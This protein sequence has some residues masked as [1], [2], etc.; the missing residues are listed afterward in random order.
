MGAEYINIGGTEFRPASFID[1][2]KKSFVTYYAGKLV[3]VD[4]N[5]AWDIIQ[6]HIKPMIREQKIKE[7]LEFDKNSKSKVVKK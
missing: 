6:D 1:A 4:I 5:D 7:K 2:D 3:N